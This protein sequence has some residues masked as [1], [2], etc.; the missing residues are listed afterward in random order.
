MEDE[1]YPRETID[2]L[3]KRIGPNEA[4]LLNNDLVLIRV[5][6]QDKLGKIFKTYKDRVDYPKDAN[7]WLFRF[8][9]IKEL[10][11]DPNEWT[12]NDFPFL[13]AAPFF[14]Y[15]SK[16]GYKILLACQKIVSQASKLIIEL[17]DPPSFETT[18]LCKTM[19]FF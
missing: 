15:T 5:V 1:K 14:N 16:R 8:G 9:F 11:W 4:K 13:G 19:T 12:W 18:D 3:L 10:P 7:F 17:K 6:Y 2:G